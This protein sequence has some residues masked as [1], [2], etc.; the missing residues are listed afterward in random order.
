MRADKTEEKKRLSAR[1][2]PVGAIPAR[3]R[4]KVREK[5]PDRFLPNSDELTVNQVG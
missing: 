2:A 4:Q 5:I 3:L 1:C